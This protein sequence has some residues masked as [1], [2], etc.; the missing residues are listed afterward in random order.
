MLKIVIALIAIG[1]MEYC[2][3]S[4]K[5]KSGAKTVPIES[6]GFEIAMAILFGAWILSGGNFLW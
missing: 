5:K 4:E 1:I 3:E 2:A 6:A